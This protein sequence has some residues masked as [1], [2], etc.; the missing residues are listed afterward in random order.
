MAYPLYMN[1]GPE[2]HLD[3][4]DADFVDIIHTDGGRLGFPIP[5]GH[6]DFYPNGGRRR[7][8]GCNIE[9]VVAMGVN[10]LLNRYSR[11]FS[12]IHNNTCYYFLS[13]NIGFFFFVFAVTCSHNR[14]WRFYAESVTNPAGFP[15]SRCPKWRPEM[16]RINC[17]WHPEALM[18]FAASPN[19]IGMFYLR[20]NGDPPYARN[21]TGYH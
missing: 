4:N 6:A 14:A 10:M 16:T 5:L 18:G 13:S 3:R 9:N 1:T 15:A 21:L 17:H 19:R 2:G 12:S 7:Q 11:F 20:T 8:P